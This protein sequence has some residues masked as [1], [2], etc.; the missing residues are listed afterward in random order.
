MANQKPKT[1]FTKDYRVRSDAHWAMAVHPVTATHQIKLKGYYM[2]LGRLKNTCHV[3]L[4]IT[5]IHYSAVSS[6]GTSAQ[7]PL[8][9]QPQAL[10]D[11]WLHAAY[12]R[13]LTTSY[14]NK[15]SMLT[16]LLTV[17]NAA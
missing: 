8:T 5:G 17:A 14:Y 16:M 12:P 15:G 11:Y 2:G 1:S 10:G 3:P 4:Q 6:I 13:R 7:R 9:F